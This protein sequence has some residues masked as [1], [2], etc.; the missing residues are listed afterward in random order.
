MA[1]AWLTPL[2]GDEKLVIVAVELVVQIKISEKARVFSEHHRQ[3]C[4]NIADR[5]CAVVTPK[6]IEQPGGE[7]AI[8]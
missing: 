8:W 7:G 1:V 2:G 5:V 6:A 4:V 3:P